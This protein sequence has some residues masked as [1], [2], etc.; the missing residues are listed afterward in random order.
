MK[1]Q[2]PITT[3]V[4]LT[5]IWRECANLR[6][7]ENN[8]KPKGTSPHPYVDG[9]SNKL[10]QSSGPCSLYNFKRKK[11][12]VA[13]WLL[14]EKSCQSL[15]WW[16]RLL[17]PALSKA[18]SLRSAWFTKW[19]PGKPK[20]RS[21]DNVSKV[22]IRVHDPF[23]IIVVCKLHILANRTNLISLVRCGGTDHYSQHSRDRG[24]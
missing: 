8:Q 5:L 10:S 17:I 12:F 14:Y 6:W 19:I 4:L 21:R 3:T 16:C 2:R 7:Q 20:L 22:A 11:A 23:Y 1:V 24:R 13:V 18:L 9:T 15:S